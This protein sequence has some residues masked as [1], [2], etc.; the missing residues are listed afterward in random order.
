M[1]TYFYDKTDQLV[2]FLVDIV[3]FPDS[4]LAEKYT[5]FLLSILAT[6]IYFPFMLVVMIYDFLKW[7]FVRKMI[8]ISNIPSRGTALEVGKYYYHFELRHCHPMTFGV[9]RPYL[10]I[11]SFRVIEA[12]EY[13]VVD[14]KRE[15][16]EG[17]WWEFRFPIGIIIEIYHR[18]NK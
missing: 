14:G 9:F 10:S 3:P 5:I 7:A 16:R 17:G 12:G 6:L 2:E 11:A 8:L 1:K 15:F 13:G 4:E 18:N